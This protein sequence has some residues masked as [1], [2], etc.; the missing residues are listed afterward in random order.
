[1]RRTASARK[2]LRAYL[3]HASV[4]HEVVGQQFGQSVLET[5]FDSWLAYTMEE[6][7]IMTNAATTMIFFMGES[8]EIKF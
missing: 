1:M 4:E 8:P 3:Q 7:A 5:T 2:P 6:I